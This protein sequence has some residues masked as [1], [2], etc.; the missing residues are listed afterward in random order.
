MSASKS[1]NFLDRI[2]PEVRSGGGRNIVEIARRLHIPVETTR[3]RVKAMMKRGLKIYASFDY[4]KFDLTSYYVHLKLTKQGLERERKLFQSLAESSYL[5]S[6][7]KKLPTNEFICSFAV[8]EVRSSSSSMQRLVRAL[9][10]E[11]IVSYS[12]VY[13]LSW[14]KSETIQP[15]YF[16][17]KKGVWQIDWEKLRKESSQS[18][19]KSEPSETS[20]AEYD[21]LDLH[22]AR[23]LEMDGLERLSSIAKRLKT[24]L[25]N[26]FY[27]FHKHMVGEKL[28]DEF[29]IGWFGNQKQETLLA[30]MELKNLSGNEE[31]KARSVFRKLPFLLTDGGSL[32]T[33]NYF[34]QAILPTS[35]YLGMLNY[36]S[37]TLGDVAGKLRISVSDSKAVQWFHLPAYLFKN[38]SWKFDPEVSASQVASKLKR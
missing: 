36:L 23:A 3:Y 21:E 33:G 15:E 28:I 7:L 31:V 26:V 32:D 6:Y 2:I 20:P 29:V 9:T 38:G 35:Q 34:G 37:S 22:I 14:K 1:K 12:R 27:H 24:T 16:H 8:P 19:E 30:H 11:G 18:K 4:N 17:L 25:N 13:R 5:I 10:E